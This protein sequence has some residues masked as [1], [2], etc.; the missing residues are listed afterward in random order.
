M[1][2]IV[3]TCT[4]RVVLALVLALSTLALPAASRAATA[5][6]AV[7]PIA[8][9]VVLRW[10]GMS[11]AANQHFEVESSPGTFSCRTTSSQCTVAVTATFPVLKFRVK[12]LSAAGA[13]VA[14]SPWS[15][16]IKTTHLIVV[17]GQ[18]N[19]AGFA[20]ETK[21]TK[22]KFNLWSGPGRSGAD[23]STDFVEVGCGMKQVGPVPQKLNTPQVLLANKATIFGPEVGIA[24]ALWSAGW[25]NVVISKVTCGGTDLEHFWYQGSDQFTLL[26]T[27]T[28]DLENWYAAHGTVA[29]LSGAFWVQGE[30]DSQDLATAN[31]YYLHAHDLIESVRSATFSVPTFPIIAGSIDM[32]MWISHTAYVNGKC[33]TAACLS[34]QAGNLAV[35]TADLRLA[36]DVPNT[37]LVDTKGLPRDPIDYVHI[38]SA[39]MIKLG[40][41]LGA[42]FLKVA[43]R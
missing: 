22:E 38:T 42:K 34:Y 31:D 25:K 8:G 37:F 9:S 43:K 32:S 11:L 21:V 13:V 28:I 6:I 35:R 15:M 33:E 23:T 18:S 26:L 14:T 41:L 3:R 10:S 40:G 36:Q 7:T 39:G 30:T 20:A 1:K 5:S 24:R 29:V 12:Q 4:R 2:P 27:T 19:A 16:S 17:A